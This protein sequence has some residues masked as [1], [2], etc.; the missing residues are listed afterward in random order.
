MKKCLGIVL[1]WFCLAGLSWGGTLGDVN[2]DGAVGLPEAVHALQVS[3][4]IRPQGVTAQYDFAEYFMFPGTLEFSVKNLS[5]TEQQRYEYNGTSDIT[6]VTVNGEEVLWY[7]GVDCY[8]IT[9]EGV[10]CR[11]YKSASETVWYDKP[12]ILGSR[13]MTPGDMFTNFY[14]DPPGSGYLRYTETIFLGT[15]DVTTPAGTFKGCL[16]MLQKYHSQ[17]SQTTS[18][19]YYAKGIGRVKRTFISG[20]SAQDH[21]LVSARI[22]TTVIPTGVLYY[23][24]SGTWTDNATTP[25]RTG[26]LAFRYAHG[27][28]PYWGRL[29]RVGFYPPSTPEGSPTDRSMTVKSDDGVHFADWSPVTGSQPMLSMT[30]ENETITGGYL[31]ASISGTYAAE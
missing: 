28:G 12:E 22:G 24:G 14:E 29:T 25:A 15:E 20:Y 10:F 5:Q 19:R 13:N 27:A 31:S 3:S 17:T 8:Q 1:A 16:K 9:P 4:G 18:I 30:I 21:Q 26:T 11:G 23:S 2:G 6:K 7:G